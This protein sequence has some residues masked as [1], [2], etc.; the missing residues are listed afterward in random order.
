MP[1]ISRNHLIR[2]RAAREVFRD[3]PPLFCRRRADLLALF[4]AH[5]LTRG[6]RRLPGLL[7]S[8]KNDRH[9]PTLLVHNVQVKGARAEPKSSALQ[10]LVPPADNDGYWQGM[11]GFL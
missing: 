5:H 11:G 9:Y 7:L 6:T 3:E 2:L 1:P 4:I 8:P 10:R